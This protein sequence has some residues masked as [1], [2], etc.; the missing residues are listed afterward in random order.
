MRNLRLC[1]KCYKKHWLEEQKQHHSVTTMSFSVDL[2][3]K[4]GVFVQADLC[5]Y[6]KQFDETAP[7][8]DECPYILEHSLCK[9]KKPT[10]KPFIDKDGKLKSLI[11]KWCFPKPPSTIP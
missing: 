1:K 6:E 11:K 3:D 8:P 10:K 9:K 5:K 7:P 2:D 4:Y